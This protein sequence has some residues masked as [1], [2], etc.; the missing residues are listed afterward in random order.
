VATTKKAGAALSKNSKKVAAPGKGTAV[1][2]AS[3]EEVKLLL[4]I[5]GNILNC[6]RQTLPAL[7]SNR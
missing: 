7:L 6:L 4:S 5:L 2:S 3:D 1:G